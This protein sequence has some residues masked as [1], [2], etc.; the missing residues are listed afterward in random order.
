[1]PPTEMIPSSPHGLAD[2]ANPFVNSHRIR[3]DQ[4]L[5]HNADLEAVLL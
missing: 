3:G 5:A 1:M 4:R 2:E